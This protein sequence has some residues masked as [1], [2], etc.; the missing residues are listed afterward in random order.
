[1]KRPALQNKAAQSFMNG[2]SGLKSFRDFQ[3]MDP[4]IH[5]HNT[6]GHQV[7]LERIIIIYCNIE[8]SNG[9]RGRREEGKS[10]KIA[11]L[12]MRQV[13]KGL[14]GYDNFLLTR[15]ERLK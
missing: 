14:L 9:G 13:L 7:Q 8:E 12:I 11:L 1:M 6:P 4:Q 2:F 15:S 5:I 10:K 3:E